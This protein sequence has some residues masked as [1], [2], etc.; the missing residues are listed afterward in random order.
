MNTIDS[1]TDLLLSGVQGYTWCST[2]FLQIK[3]NLEAGTFVPPE[4]ELP[5]IGRHQASSD[6]RQQALQCI[7]LAKIGQ[8]LADTFGNDLDLAREPVENTHRP[9]AGGAA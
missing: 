2:L 8:Y 5:R 6:V 3:Q 4:L 1:T 9:V 7:E